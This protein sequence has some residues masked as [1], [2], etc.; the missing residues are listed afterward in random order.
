M[1]TSPADLFLFL[2]SAGSTVT[3]PFST[4][5]PRGTLGGEAIFDGEEFSGS[6]KFYQLTTDDD[7]ISVSAKID[8]DFSDANAIYDLYVLHKEGCNPEDA[9]NYEDNHEEENE[10]ACYRQKYRQLNSRKRQASK[11]Q[12]ETTIIYKRRR[13]TIRFQS[14]ETDMENSFNS[15]VLTPPLDGALLNKSDLLELCF[16]PKDIMF[17]LTPYVFAYL[18]KGI[19]IVP[20]PVLHLNN[21]LNRDIVIKK[22]G[23]VIAR[24]TILKVF[25]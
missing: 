25:N 9:Y 5:A 15:G 23:K 17:D 21:V 10:Y 24:T 14:S 4:N 11:A 7:N 19:K 16:N 22:N 12:S 1:E 6:I 13:M 18:S 2:L 8:I 20:L 3:A